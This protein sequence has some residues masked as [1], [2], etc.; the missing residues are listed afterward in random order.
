MAKLKAIDEYTFKKDGGWFIREK[1][2]TNE[3]ILAGNAQDNE[4][5]RLLLN[6][7]Q[8]DNLVNDETTISR[9]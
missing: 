1:Y 5:N 6:Q 2:L 3:P 7:L 8:T 4:P 9:D